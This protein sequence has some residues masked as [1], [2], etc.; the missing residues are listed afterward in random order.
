MQRVP[1]KCAPGA[2][3]EPLDAA[4]GIALA[5]LLSSALWV[6]LAVTAWTLW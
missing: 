3:A 4:R 2:R 1:G 6:G 5:V